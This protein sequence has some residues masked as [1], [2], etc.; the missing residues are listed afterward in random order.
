MR[1]LPPK[2]VVRVVL[3]PALDRNTTPVIYIND[4][5]CHTIAAHPELITPEGAALIG[6]Q[7]QGILDRVSAA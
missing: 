6:A 1:A 2:H 4:G 5:E 3:D 7:F